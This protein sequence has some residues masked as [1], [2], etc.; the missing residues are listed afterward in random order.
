M[1]R[2]HVDIR[3]L[4]EG[5]KDGNAILGIYSLVIGYSGRLLQASL[6]SSRCRVNTQGGLG[7]CYPCLL[8]REISGVKDNDK[9]LQAM[10][11]QS[12]LH[13]VR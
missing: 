1:N 3:G 2:H 6:L 7:G 12:S 9:H 5:I 11:T 4:R 10:E 13:V 8:D